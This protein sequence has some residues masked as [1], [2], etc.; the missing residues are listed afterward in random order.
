MVL[1]FQGLGER[2]PIGDYV[3]SSKLPSGSQGLGVVETAVLGGAVALAFV[4]I[5][6]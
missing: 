6:R 1:G 3:S 4:L 5:I 2:G